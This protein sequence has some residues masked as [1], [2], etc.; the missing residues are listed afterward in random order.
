MMSFQEIKATIFGLLIAIFG[1][2]VPLITAFFA[3][4]GGE[5]EI[6]NKNLEDVLENVRKSKKSDN[7]IDADNRADDIK[8]LR[9]F[10]RD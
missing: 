5:N 7:I 1:F 10:E 4:K 3:R 6:N 9:N 8:F 2:I